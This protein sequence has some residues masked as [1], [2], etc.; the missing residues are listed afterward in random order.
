[1]ENKNSEW[2]KISARVPRA[3]V[4]KLGRLH[5][6]ETLS[7]LLRQLLERE[8]TRQKVLDAHKRLYG[9][10]QPKDFDESIL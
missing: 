8:I 6:E 7:A 10:F 3:L 4:V 9:R 1:M 5:P 2:I